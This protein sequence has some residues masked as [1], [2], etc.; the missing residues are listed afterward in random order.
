VDNAPKYFDIVPKVLMVFKTIELKVTIVF[1]C[2][3]LYCCLFAFIHVVFHL[4]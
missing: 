2:F 4:I 1:I 3:V